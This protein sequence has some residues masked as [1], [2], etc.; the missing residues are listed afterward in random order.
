M[1]RECICQRIFA[2]FSRV[3]S[4]R[5]YVLRGARGGANCAIYV[6]FVIWALLRSLVGEISEMGL[7]EI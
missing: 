4:V 5:E 2:R 1:S 3:V 7:G 6:Q